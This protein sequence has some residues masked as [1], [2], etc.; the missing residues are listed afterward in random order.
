LLNCAVNPVLVH[1]LDYTNI[2]LLVPFTGEFI[3][4]THWPAPAVEALLGHV[5]LWWG[6]IYK[7][8]RL[9]PGKQYFPIFL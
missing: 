3:H 8:R 5:L 6:N 4:N 9:N 2:Y 7:A 1:V